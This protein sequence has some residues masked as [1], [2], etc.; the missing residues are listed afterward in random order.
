MKSF[1]NDSI[2]KVNSEAV[3]KRCSVKQALKKSQENN[4]FDKF[5]KISSKSF[6]VNFTKFLRTRFLHDISK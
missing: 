5:V 3:I 2:H 6:S 4:I 1:R